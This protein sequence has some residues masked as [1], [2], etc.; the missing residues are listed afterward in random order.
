MQSLEELIG[1]HPKFL[2][3]LTLPMVLVLVALFAIGLLGLFSQIKKSS[4]FRGNSG[5]HF[6]AIFIVLLLVG[7]IGNGVGLIIKKGS[8]NEFYDNLE[9]ATI[10]YSE[11]NFDAHKVTIQ[12]SHY[13]GENYLVEVGLDNITHK[14]VVH[15]KYSDEHDMLVPYGQIDYETLPVKEGSPLDSLIADNEHLSINSIDEMK[16]IGKELRTTGYFG[17]VIAF[18]GVFVLAG[19]YLYFCQDQRYSDYADTLSFLVVFFV[20]AGVLYG[21]SWFWHSTKPEAA[22]NTASFTAYHIEENYDIDVPIDNMSTSS[23]IEESVTVY[24]EDT[25]LEKYNDEALVFQLDEDYNMFMIH[26]DETTLE[27]P[28]PVKEDS[29]L[30]RLM[31]AS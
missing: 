14:T 4:R 25:E 23:S 24:T 1:N 6:F 31:E 18:L 28:L 8:E 22:I 20:S 16:D 17:I 7:Q 9:T 29:P 3:F 19:S 12:E 26:H 10:N 13:D 27:E 5:K 2:D 11:N 21:V 15:M 30:E